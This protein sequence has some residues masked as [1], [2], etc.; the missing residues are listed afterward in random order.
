MKVLE[1]LKQRIAEH[2][3]GGEPTEGAAA[4]PSLGDRRPLQPRQR[5]LDLGI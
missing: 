4:S 1:G 2:E 3:W 5:R